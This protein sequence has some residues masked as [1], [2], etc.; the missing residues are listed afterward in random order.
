M[1]KPRL[2]VEQL[3]VGRFEAQ[4]AAG[5]REGTVHAHD[6]SGEWSDCNIHTCS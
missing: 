4:T 3:P 6:A 2:N 5:T 1:Q